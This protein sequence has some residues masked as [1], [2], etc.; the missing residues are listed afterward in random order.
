MIKSNFFDCETSSH[1]NISCKPS[2]LNTDNIK[3][4]VL[5]TCE[6]HT[7]IV[8]TR[9]WPR[10]NDLRKYKSW[11]S[12]EFRLHLRPDIV[13]QSCQRLPS[14]SVLDTNG[15]AGVQYYYFRQKK[16]P[17]DYDGGSNRW[18]LVAAVCYGWVRHDVT[19]QQ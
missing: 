13:T 17:D 2:R 11:L 14:G 7:L 12:P 16:S 10:M 18:N 5:L 15:I 6:W 8:Y 3:L 4:R 19:G 1:T 9:A